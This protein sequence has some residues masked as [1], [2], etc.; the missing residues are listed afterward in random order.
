M[1][2]L[3][4]NKDAD[5]YLHKI[6]RTY[7][8]VK[9]ELITPNKCTKLGLSI[10]KMINSNFATRVNINRNKTFWCFGVRFS[11]DNL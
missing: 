7:T 10:D 3:K 5:I 1:E 11:N 4:I 8:F 6:K 2:F 9:D